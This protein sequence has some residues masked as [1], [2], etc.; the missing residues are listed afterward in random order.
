ML[1]FQ[2]E[3]K[4]VELRKHPFFRIEASVG[5]GKGL[6]AMDRG[7]ERGRLDNG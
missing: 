7:G 4:K 2:M 3:E 5:S 6:L 1:L